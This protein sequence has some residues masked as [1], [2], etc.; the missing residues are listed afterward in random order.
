MTEST[1]IPQKA[2]PLGPGEPVPAHDVSSGGTFAERK[3][4]RESAES[5]AV[6]KDDELVENKA[7]RKRASRK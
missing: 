7:V 6:E 1:D 2:T 3:A 5:K 4:A